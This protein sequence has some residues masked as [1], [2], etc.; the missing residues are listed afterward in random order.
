MVTIIA[1]P[2]A[3]MKN[4][5]WL[6][7]IHLDVRDMDNAAPVQF[8][9]KKGASWTA[10]AAGIYSVD[11]VNS[12]VEHDGEVVEGASVVAADTVLKVSIPGIRSKTPPGGWRS[13]LPSKGS[14]KKKKKKKK[15]KN[16]KKKH[17]TSRKRK[18]SK[19]TRRRRR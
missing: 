18:S 4:G 19:K 8:E 15:K 13:Y 12:V 11:R 16:K 9:L 7:W 10:N 5:K 14:M 3:T 2:K 1:T 6:Q 17:Q